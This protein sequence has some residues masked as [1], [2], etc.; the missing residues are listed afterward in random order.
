MLALSALAVIG[1]VAVATA[2]EAHASVKPVVAPTSSGAVDAL[3]ADGVFSL[4]TLETLA[5]SAL[6][7]FQ[8]AARLDAAVV[9]LCTGTP[10]ELN[11][12]FTIGI[13]NAH[14]H[15]ACTRYMRGRLGVVSL[16][17]A[18]D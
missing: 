12:N 13:K 4:Q 9:T 1:V 15:E 10:N 7:T 8:A 11:P 16:V 14:Q 5:D 18:R 17:H 3:V 6:R 2:L